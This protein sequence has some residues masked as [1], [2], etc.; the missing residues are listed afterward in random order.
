MKRIFLISSLNWL[1]YKDLTYIFSILFHYLLIVILIYNK[2]SNYSIF[3]IFECIVLIISI[4]TV[5]YLMKK[6]RSKSQTPLYFKWYLIS[7]L[8]FQFLLTM[9]LLLKSL[10]YQMSLSEVV[11]ALVISFTLCFGLSNILIY[12]AIIWIWIYYALLKFFFPKERPAEIE[13]HIAIKKLSKY[14]TLFQQK[15]YLNLFLITTLVYVVAVLYTVLTFMKYNSIN[16]S[17]FESIFG[18]KEISELFN[19]GNWLG[20]VSLALAVFSITIPLSRKIYTTALQEYFEEQLNIEIQE[21]GEKLTVNEKDII[22]NYKNNPSPS[23]NRNYKLFS[24]LIIF[25]TF[26]KIVHTFTKKL[27]SI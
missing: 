2:Q 21:D 26:L 8:L 10:D 17:I 11:Y 1:T 5:I 3:F 22:K 16:N 15:L 20:I 18:N 4:I 13:E 23:I 9:L 7:T 27:K 19:L 6:N 25:Y 14:L 24:F 12:P